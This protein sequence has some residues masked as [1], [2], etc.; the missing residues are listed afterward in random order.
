MRHRTAFYPC[1]GSDFATP[2]SL[3]AGVVDEVIFCDV[4]E[5]SLPS[6]AT[7]G[8]PAPPKATFLLGDV[9]EIVGKLRDVDVIFYRRDSNGEG[10]S[11]IYVLGD[12]FLPGLLGAFRPCGGID[13][14]P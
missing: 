4:R 5:L 1:C 14:F 11:G 12:S 10:G 2:L 3:L 7:S 8:F 13:L 6:V 9:R